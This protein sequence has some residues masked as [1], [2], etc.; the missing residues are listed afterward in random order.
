LVLIEKIDI[1]R[2]GDE[3][4]KARERGSLR[5]GRRQIDQTP[6][7]GAANVTPKKGAANV[8]PEKGAEILYA[9]E[10]GRKKIAQEVVEK[11]DSPGRGD[12]KIEEQK[13]AHLIQRH[14]KKMPK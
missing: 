5:R 10:R 6:K 3:R 11:T 1:P 14:E 13:V 4:L 2:R 9:Q 12:V 8:M 7:K